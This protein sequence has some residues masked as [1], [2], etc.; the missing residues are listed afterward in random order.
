MDTLNNKAA[1]PGVVP[2]M[3]VSAPVV[4]LASEGKRVHRGLHD[5]STLENFIVNL[6]LNVQYCF[7]S[8]FILFL[9]NDQHLKMSSFSFSK[10]ISFVPTIDIHVGMSVLM[11]VTLTFS[12][13][14]NISCIFLMLFCICFHLRSVLTAK[15]I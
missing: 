8:Y 12:S 3:A 7:M 4:Q 5:P 11:V 13:S 2:H 15:Y 1:P 9:L 6:F 14:L 10:C